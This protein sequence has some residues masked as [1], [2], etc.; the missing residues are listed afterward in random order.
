MTHAAFS[1]FQVEQF[2]SELEH[3]VVYNF[4]ESGVHPMSL[5]GLV[6]LADIDMSGLMQTMLDYPQVNG[7][8]SLRETISGLY[9]G[10]APDG[11]MITVGATEAN[12]LVANTLL[13][14]G[15]NV[16]CFRPTYE[17]I[18]GNALNRGNEVRWVD[19]IEA[20]S[21]AIDHD[22]LSKAVDDK[23][24][25]IHVVN[26]NNPTG[27]VISDN[28]RAAI[29]A[30]AEHVGAWIVADE[31]YAGTERE[32]DAETPS[33]WGSY[34]K[35]LIV[36]SMSKAYGLPGLRLG[37]LVGPDEIITEC[38]RR[39]EYASIAASM[40]SMEL[41]DIALAEPTR[42]RLKARARQLIRT[43]F[44][45]LAQELSHYQ[46][47]YSVVPP[48]A[49]AMSF[50][51]FNLPITSE[52]LASRLLMEKDVLVIPGSRFSVE[53]H[54]RVSSALPEDHLRKGLTLLNDLT[55]DI[56]AGR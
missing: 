49:S 9:P 14:P 26:P 28:D 55:G 24:R 48:K 11:V 53:G 2:L 21:W 15:D 23:T 18:S 47:V 20:D 46:G 10:S 7:K 50:V 5:Q 37:W 1:P 35:V 13:Q 29:I 4:S 51:R 52:E 39:H 45:V 12:S 17:Q 44:D 19:L 3:G 27:Q 6:D 36:N 38:W 40:L 8:Q 32:G 43:G 33:F 34:D 42:S 25:I 16:V 30:A 22:A 54:F 56:L 41:A 31:V